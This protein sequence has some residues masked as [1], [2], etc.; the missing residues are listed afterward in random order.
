MRTIFAI[1]LLPLPSEQRTF[2]ARPATERQQW[3]VRATV[4]RTEAGRGARQPSARLCQ[5]SSIGIRWL[6]QRSVLW[7]EPRLGAVRFRR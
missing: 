4:N 3:K 5:L 6:T 1:L 7:L 2:I